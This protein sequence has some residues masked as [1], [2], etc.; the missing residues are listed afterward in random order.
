MGCFAG[1]L[2]GRLDHTIAAINTLHMY[3]HLNI[4]LLGD[5]NMVGQDFGF[6]DEV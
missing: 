5:G 3:P 6:R 2:G 1:A 4:I